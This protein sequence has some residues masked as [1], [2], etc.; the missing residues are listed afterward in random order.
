MPSITSATKCVKSVLVANG[1]LDKTVIDIRF[2]L[3]SLMQEMFGSASY[4]LDFFS[5][6]Y[7]ADPCLAHLEIQGERS[8]HVGGA[9]TSNMIHWS[10][11]LCMRYT[12]YSCH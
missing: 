6:R 12:K 4:L 8:L 9:A 3:Y 5:F 2:V 7:F 1:I 11:D 10:T